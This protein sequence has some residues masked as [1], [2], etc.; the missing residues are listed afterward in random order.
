MRR[1]QFLETAKGQKSELRKR[2][3]ARLLCLSAQLPKSK[4]SIKHW[5][6]EAFQNELLVALGERRRAFRKSVI[7]DLSFNPTQNNPPHI[8]TLA[9]NY[10]D[11]LCKPV[12]PT[13]SKR[14]AIVMLDDRQVSFLSVSFSTFHGPGAKIVVEVRAGRHFAADLRLLAALR[15]G[16]FGADPSRDRDGIWPTEAEDDDRWA[17]I[18]Q[19]QELQERREHF[20]K[21]YGEETYEATLRMNIAAAQR[22]ILRSNTHLVHT[23]LIDSFRPDEGDFAAEY[24]NEFLKSP[25]LSLDLKHLPVEGGST[26]FKSEVSAALAAF[27]KKYPL[28]ER[29]ETPTSVTILLTPPE[30]GKDIDLDN[31]A[32]TYVVPA[33]H[34]M[35]APPLT[36]AS[37]LLESGSP[38]WKERL[39]AMFENQTGIPK[40]SITHYQVA[41][42]ARRDKDPKQGSVRLVLCDGTGVRSFPQAVED[43]IDRWANER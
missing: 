41:R 34:E 40:A 2:W 39:K 22:S 26:L 13:V 27:K 35:L 37:R 23:L 1:S 28:F 30:V 31:L 3:L 36:S 11:L 29:L 7:L 17:R 42:L 32:R 6:K 10:I 38:E 20:L 19:V 25:H 43:A 18:E 33:V 14:G 8:H 16:E 4:G 24:S 15:Q 21:S 9:K 5:E 12:S